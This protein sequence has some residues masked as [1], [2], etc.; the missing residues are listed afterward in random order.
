MLVKLVVNSNKTMMLVSIP[1]SQKSFCEVTIPLIHVPP[2]SKCI[3]TVFGF[4]L[5]FC[6]HSVQDYQFIPLFQK[7]LQEQKIELSEVEKQVLG[8]NAEM[9]PPN[10]SK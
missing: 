9:K 6:S 1:G 4:V 7:A 8:T 2:F 10:S 3:E 5:G